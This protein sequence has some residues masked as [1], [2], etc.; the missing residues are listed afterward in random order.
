MLLI[1]SPKIQYKHKSKPGALDLI[2][3][4]PLGLLGHMFREYGVLALGFGAVAL[5]GVIV[6][7]TRGNVN[8][9]LLW[10]IAKI[11]GYVLLALSNL[12]LA[13]IRSGKRKKAATDED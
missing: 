1:R 6:A 4:I 2:Y 7:I 9:N 12:I 10:E 11:V 13:F 5:G 8:W 3:T